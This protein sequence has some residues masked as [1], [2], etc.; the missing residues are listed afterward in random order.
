MELMQAIMII[1]DEKR[2]AE[3]I[4]T[5]LDKVEHGDNVADRIRVAIQ[6]LELME[7]QLEKAEQRL[8]DYRNSLDFS[9]L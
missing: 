1:E 6:G 5:S 2:R 4:R 7:K 9:K 3:F 8:R